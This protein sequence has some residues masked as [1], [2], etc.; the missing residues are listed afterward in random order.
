MASLTVLNDRHVVVISGLAEL[1]AGAI[2]MG[3]GQ[4]MTALLKREHY[5]SEEAREKKEIECKP[6]E[7]AA[8]IHEILGQYG[9]SYNGT[10]TVINDLKANPMLYLQVRLNRIRNH[11]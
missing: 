6:E 11:F 8:E 5:L 10:R 7:E 2:S 3:L 1:F 4:F 9:V